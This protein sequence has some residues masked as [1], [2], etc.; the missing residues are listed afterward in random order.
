MGYALFVKLMVMWLVR[1]RTVVD[2][3][4][5]DTELLGQELVIVLRVRDCRLED[6]QNWNCS[7]TRGVSEYRTRL[8]DRLAADVIDDQTRLARRRANV[9]RLRA[10][11]DRLGLRAR[12]AAALLLGAGLG[13]ATAQTAPLGRRLGLGRSLG[14]GGVGVRLGCRIVLARR[15][16]GFGVLVLRLL[17]DLAGLGGD[18]GCLGGLL[19]RLGLLR[20]GSGLI[21]DVAGDL[22]RVAL[23]VRRLRSLLVLRLFAHRPLTLS[24]PA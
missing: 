7:C 4:L 8:L 19:G 23:V 21:G 11:E 2:Q 18:R 10:D 24:E 6:L 16:V 3:H 1:L 22:C 12:P 13:R 17:G 9:L 14:L 20:V 5:V 15:L